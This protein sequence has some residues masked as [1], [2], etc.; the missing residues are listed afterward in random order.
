MSS[1][2]AGYARVMARIR[3]KQQ[4]CKPLFGTPHL[5]LGQ[6]LA[7][8][9]YSFQVGLIL[10][11]KYSTQ[12]AF[13]HA[14][15]GA[16]GPP[17]A[18]AKFFSEV[19]KTIIAEYDLASMTFRDYVGSSTA[20]L[21]HYSGDWFAMARQNGTAKLH[22]QKAE[23]WAWRYSSDGAAVGATHPDLVRSMYERTYAR[24]NEQEWRR[25]H[26]IGLDIPREQEV[27]SYEMAESTEDALF[28]AYCKE[29]CPEH[30]ATLTE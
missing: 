21:T 12:D 27:F 30:H 4:A 26:D 24:A 1:Q 3:V 28:M 15:V 10:G 23:E 6:C 7:I 16:S 9:G 20:R 2:F 22:L 5:K 29:F 19:A 13:G 18:I 8:W 17:G 11:A 25:M 14:F